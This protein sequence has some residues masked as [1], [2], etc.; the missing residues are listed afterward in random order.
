MVG[1]VSEWRS[2]TRQ[3]LLACLE[4]KETFHVAW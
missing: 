1:A 3:Q 2:K 4:T